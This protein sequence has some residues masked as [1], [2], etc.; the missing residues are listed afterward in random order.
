MILIDKRANVKSK[1]LSA[2]IVGSD[3]YQA[4]LI[5]KL[6]LRVHWGV[7]NGGNAGPA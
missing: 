5:D 4:M 1:I 7:V 6:G 3:Y 2:G